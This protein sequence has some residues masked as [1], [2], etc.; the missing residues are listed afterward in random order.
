MSAKPELVDL[1]IDE[2]IAERIHALIDELNP[3]VAAL[4]LRRHPV[5]QNII[6]AEKANSVTLGRNASGGWSFE[7]KAYAN[8]VEDAMAKVTA[9]ASALDDAHP[10]PLKSK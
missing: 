10:A 2:K 3:D 8:S 5:V 9:T 4:V 1:A 6:A 7:V